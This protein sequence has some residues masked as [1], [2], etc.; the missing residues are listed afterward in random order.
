MGVGYE[1]D[2][3]IARIWFDR[4]DKHNALRDEDLSALVEALERLDRDDSA[5]IAILFGEGRSFSSGGD[6][7]ERLTRSM[8][9]GSTSGRTSEGDVFLRGGSWKPVI[10]AVHGYCLGHA[11]GLVLQCDLVVA[12]RG[13]RFQVT[14][15]KFGLPMATF[16]PRLGRPGFANEVCMTG[17]MFG[18][19][20][21][22]DAGFVTEVVDDGEHLRAAE[23]LGRRILENP[24]AG[25]REHVRARRTV[26][27][28]AADHY[29]GFSAE[30]R[31]GWATDAAARTAVAARASE[32]GGGAR[33]GS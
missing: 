11:L 32:L 26:L 10:A 33:A 14:E 25:V 18:A 29:L 27:A 24:Q 5:D 21:G 12:A 4:V 31:Q 23:S 28:E 3:R 22:R 19:E 8:D 15:I 6:V 16:L 17:R 20:E 7:D 9:E 13:T 30:F 2:D 1:V